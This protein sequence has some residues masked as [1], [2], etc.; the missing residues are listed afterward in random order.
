MPD[1][2]TIWDVATGTGDWAFDRPSQITWVDQ[3]G[4]SIVDQHGAAIGMTFIAGSGLVSA[5]DLYTAVLISLFTDAE[6]P[7]DAVIPDGSNDRRGWWAGPIGS[8]LWLL[9][10]SKATPDL[11][12]RVKN[13]IEQALQWLL[14]D[15]V[16][17][18]IEVTAEYLTGS[19]IGAVVVL[20][21]Q[22]G[23]RLALRFSKVWENI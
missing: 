4:N 15:Q 10:R 23:A 19:A 21:R 8:L 18:A 17:A 22:D 12:A 3:N 1:I 13:Y 7:A 5:Q 14:D 6:A 9:E 16:V 20:R 11:P 2:A